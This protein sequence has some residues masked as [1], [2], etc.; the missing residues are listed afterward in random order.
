MRSFASLNALE[1]SALLVLA[2]AGLVA[3]STSFV[4]RCLTGG[5]RDR[6]D[7]LPTT[8]GGGSARVV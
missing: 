4:A 1:T 3:G 2:S 7:F 5:P 6:L 8:V